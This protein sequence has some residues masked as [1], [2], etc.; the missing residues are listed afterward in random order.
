MKKRIKM[1][2]IVLAICIIGGI[3]MFSLNHQKEKTLEE[4][5]RIEQERMVLYLVNHYEGINEIEF[6]DVEN[7]AT[8]GS[9]TALLTL[10]KELEMEITFFKFNDKTDNYVISWNKRLNLQ[11]KN[12][13]T[14]QQTIDNIKVKYWSK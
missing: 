2:I 9:R 7:N 1:N 4:K 11:E 5:M 10:N 8:T 3:V 12:E 13:I 14:N 6:N